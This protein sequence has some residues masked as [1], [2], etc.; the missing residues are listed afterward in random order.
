MR[1]MMN[2]V[3]IVLAVLAYTALSVSI[4][5]ADNRSYESQP[6][7]PFDVGCPGIFGVHV[8]YAVNSKPISIFVADFDGIN[9][10]DIAVACY[11]REM[12]SVILNNGNGTFGPFAWYYVPYYTEWVDG[13][14]VEGDG[15]IDLVTANSNDGN[16]AVLL[17][18]GDAT[19]AMRSF[20][21][22]SGN[23]RCVKAAHLNA[24]DFVDL[25]TADYWTGRISVLFGDGDGTFG[26]SVSF[27]AGGNPRTVFP[28]DVDHDLDIDVVS[29]NLDSNSISILLNNGS[30]SFTLQPRR[31][32]GPGPFTV[33][34]ADLNGDQRPD[35]VTS[36]SGS[37]TVSVLIHS[38]QGASYQPQISYSV[39][40]HPTCVV[41]F[42]VDNDGDL[43]LATSNNDDFSA[44]VLLNKG[45]GTFGHLSS[46]ATG[47]VPYSLGAADLDGDDDLDLAVA[48]FN[49]N[50]VSILRN[51]GS[52]P[53]TASVG[54]I[55][56]NHLAQP[57]SGVVAT[58]AG[59]SVTA[60]TDSSGAYLLAGLCCGTHDLVFSHPDYCDTVIDDIALLAPDDTVTVNLEMNYRSIVGVVT[61]S[62]L[63]PVESVVVSVPLAELSDTTALDGSYYFAG[64][65]GYYNSIMFSHP[66]FCDTLIADVPTPLNDSTVLNL[67]MNHRG[68]IAGVVSNAD[69]EPIEGVRVSALGTPAF[70]SSD[71]GGMYVL[72]YLNAGSFDIL[73]ESGYYYDSLVTGAVVA[74]GDTTVLDVSLRRRPD[75]EAW[76]GNVEPAPILARVG[77]VIAVNLYLRTA[78]EISISAVSL[79]LGAANQYIDSLL[80]EAQGVIYSPLSDLDSAAFLPPIGAPP[81]DPGWSS[82]VLRAAVM[83]PLDSMLLDLDHP[84]LV[85]RF[86][87]KLVLD[88]S[89]VGDTIDCLGPGLDDA[90]YPSFALGPDGDTLSLV[91][92]FSPVLFHYLYAYLPGDANMQVGAWPPVVLGNDLTYLVNWLRGME[93]SQPCVIGGF[94]AVADANGDCQVLGS[95]VTMLVNYFRGL[96]SVRSCPLI[97]PEWPNAVDVPA[98]MPFGWPG[99]ENPVLGSVGQVLPGHNRG[100]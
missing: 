73:F 64:L 58:V 53:F 45:D 93:S 19:F 77:G 31:P 98:D 24:D 25:V 33:I 55:I 10:P 63:V 74:H 28:V 90:G 35:L 95:D 59:S 97:P 89:L 65:T 48:L 11:W 9:G 51:S 86:V 96:T 27:L 71:A 75:I 61:D 100:N 43:D 68:F 83:V 46:Y 15:D 20:Y 85:A 79:V 40:G 91:A 6:G 54:G 78:G 5:S 76:F 26:Q 4:G 22:V 60:T 12:V 13:A 69:G 88:S 29:A 62:E 37:G 34:A 70:D 44:S 16:V 66:R 52:I 72:N 21:S 41:A 94:W 23:P 67:I 82:Q 84:I 57:I 8:D 99:C 36:N 18:N 32:V 50:Y 92:H 2:R 87:A 30:G 42:D 39:L 81:N 56:S 14:D 17:N 80:S 49:S 3:S 38:G 47:H 1:A 7:L